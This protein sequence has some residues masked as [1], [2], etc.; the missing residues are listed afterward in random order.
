[1]STNGT[2]IHRFV[3][4]LNSKSNRSYILLAVLWTGLT[5][6]LSLASASTM[7]K[8]NIWDFFG[9]DKLGHLAF[10]TIFSFLWCMGLA[11]EKP[12]MMLYVF[13]FADSFGF[14]MEIAQSF[15]SRGRILEIN[16]IIAN[17]LGV[18]LGILL[19]IIFKRISTYQNTK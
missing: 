8:L 6:Y 18:I 10:Y 4:F 7:A 15:M 9:I 14:I 17:T 12:M 19:F 2:I 13:V 11:R 1:M 3:G 16:D 5:L